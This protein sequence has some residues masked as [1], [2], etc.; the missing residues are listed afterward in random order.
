[1]FEFETFGPLANT[2]TKTFSLFVDSSVDN[3]LHQTDADVISR[4]LNSSAFLNVI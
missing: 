4:F 2:G 1:M 3:V